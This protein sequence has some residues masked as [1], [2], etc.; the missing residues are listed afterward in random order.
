MAV[1]ALSCGGAGGGASH[2]GVPKFLAEE[3]E[4]ADLMAGL[5][6]LDAAGKLELDR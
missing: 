3:R 4:G 2:Y 1:V 6:V 5:G